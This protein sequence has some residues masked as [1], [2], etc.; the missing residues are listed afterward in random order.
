MSGPGGEVEPTVDETIDLKYDGQ[1]LQRI[2]SSLNPLL[3]RVVRE[4]LDSELHP[5]MM[6]TYSKAH[7]EAGWTRSG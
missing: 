1:D 6:K 2:L 3:E 5:G 7:V 4:R